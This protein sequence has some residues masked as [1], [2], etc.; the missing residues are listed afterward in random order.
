MK[1]LGLVVGFGL[2]A[3]AWLPAADFPAPPVAQ[4]FLGLFAELR[5]A[6]A[7]P[8]DKRRHVSFALTDREINDYMQYALRA[9]P[10]PGVDS[11]T[12]KIFPHNYVS[13]FMVID[14]DAVEQW[15]PGTIPAILRPVLHGKQSVWL[16]GRFLVANEAISFSVEKAYFDKI[17]L[18][19]FF[20]EKMIQIVAGRQPEHYDTSKP[21]AAPFGL[22]QLWT[23]EQVLKGSN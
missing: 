19:A 23:E 18:P 11:V 5:A 20:V 6:E 17:R 8:A 4:K 12:I 1:K 7:Q 3:R 2:L 14:F 13:T 22:Q 15:K 9:T 21:V 16:D 10:R